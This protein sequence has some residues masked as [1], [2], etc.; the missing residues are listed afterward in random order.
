MQTNITPTATNITAENL[1]NSKGTVRL[2]NELGAHLLEVNYDSEYPWPV[3]PDGAGHSLVLAR[4]SY[5]EGD[6]RAWAPSELIGG[7]PG[8]PESHVAE[9]Q[10]AV[11]SN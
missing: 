8:R 4:P 10:R 7:S 11:V 5:G 2:E 6:A 3:A 9:P 1:P